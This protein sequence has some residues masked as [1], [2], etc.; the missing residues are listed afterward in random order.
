MAFS[1]VPDLD[2]GE[3]VVPAMLVLHPVAHGV[4]V[5]SPALVGELT[6][7]VPFEHQPQGIGVF[8]ELPLNRCAVI[9]HRQD[10]FPPFVAKGNRA[11][12]EA[13]VFLVGG[14]LLNALGNGKRRGG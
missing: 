9:A 10:A 8:E 13:A 6:P 4:E 5:L 14:L 1:K 3:E 2:V 11:P 7:A 12:N